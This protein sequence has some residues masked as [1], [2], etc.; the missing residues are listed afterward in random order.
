[1][2][3]FLLQSL[4]TLT[5]ASYKLPIKPTTNDVYA[6]KDIF[7]G[8]TFEFDSITSSLFQ[9]FETTTLGY[10]KESDPR[11]VMEIGKDW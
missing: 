5:P 2:F 6:S 8:G 10:S 3:F 7:N 1:M 4:G 11:F 9:S